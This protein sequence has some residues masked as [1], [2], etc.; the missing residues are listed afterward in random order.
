MNY[1]LL[2][3]SQRECKHKTSVADAKVLCNPTA[4]E[5]LLHCVQVYV[6]LSRGTFLNLQ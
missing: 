6:A 4:R 2:C 3:S 5:R 1:G